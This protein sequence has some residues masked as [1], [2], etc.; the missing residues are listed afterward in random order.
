MSSRRT[1]RGSAPHDPAPHDAAPAKADVSVGSPRARWVTTPSGS[2]S[3]IA[4]SRWRSVASTTR[5]RSAHRATQEERRNSAFGVPGVVRA[6][7]VLR[8]RARTRRRRRRDLV[9]RN[10]RAAEKTRGSGSFRRRARVCGGGV[11]RRLLGGVRALWPAP[12]SPNPCSSCDTWACACR[13]RPC[14]VSVGRDSVAFGSLTSTGSARRRCSG[15]SAPRTCAR[16]C[17]S[18]SSRL[19]RVRRRPRR[20]PRGTTGYNGRPPVTA[21]GAAQRMTRSRAVRGSLARCAARFCRLTL[22]AVK[23]PS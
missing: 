20:R 2:C 12:W 14:C 11:A 1:R 17:A 10:R 5:P 7:G 4:A 21:R 16:T 8:R 13:T 23:A 15:L 19:P 18:A 9:G 22:R 3:P 6:R